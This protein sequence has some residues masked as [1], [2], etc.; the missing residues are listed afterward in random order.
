M[1]KL[2]K[3]GIDLASVNATEHLHST[4]SPQRVILTSLSYRF[5]SKLQLKYVVL[6][7]LWCLFYRKESQFKS[8]FSCLRV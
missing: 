4:L 6:Q 1:N 7:V 5:F 8:H 3:D 2:V